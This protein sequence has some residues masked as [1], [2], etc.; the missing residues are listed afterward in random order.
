MPP[1]PLPPTLKTA[2]P[3][4]LA[5]IRGAFGITAVDDKAN[6]TVELAATVR[7]DLLPKAETPTD[8]SDPVGV[9]VYSGGTIRSY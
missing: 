3:E 9:F 6:R 7:P 4:E 2:E 1:S 8:E 5:D